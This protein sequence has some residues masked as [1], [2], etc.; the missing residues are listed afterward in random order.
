MQ[1]PATAILSRGR[2]RPCK[3]GQT[4]LTRAS[5]VFVADRQH[6]GRV[7]FLEVLPKV[8]QIQIL[9]RIAGQGRESLPFFPRPQNSPGHDVHITIGNPHGDRLTLVAA[10][11]K[12]RWGIDQCHQYPG[13]KQMIPP[14]KQCGRMCR[15]PFGTVDQSGL[16]EATFSMRR[17]RSRP[18][19]PQIFV[20]LSP[21]IR[22]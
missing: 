19:N 21:M 11:N 22:T 1:E 12:V 6:V 7:P 8:E 9:Q 14:Q 13:I 17:K 3:I 20:S 5:P 15:N 4:A 16:A 10:K 18:L 2:S